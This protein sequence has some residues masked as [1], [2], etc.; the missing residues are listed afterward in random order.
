M[1][2][3][4]DVFIM[5][6]NQQQ[7]QLHSKSDTISAQVFIYYAIN[8]EQKETAYESSSNVRTL[9]LSKLEHSGQ[10]VKTL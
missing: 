8:L 9:E 1:N 3:D 2:K 6:G 5:L 4:K 7:Q 10:I